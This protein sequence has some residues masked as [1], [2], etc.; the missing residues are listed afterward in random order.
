MSAQHF[1]APGGHYTGL[2][3]YNEMKPRAFCTQHPEK[4]MRRLQLWNPAANKVV[5]ARGVPILHVWEASVAAARAHIGF[6]DCRP[7]WGSDPGL[8]D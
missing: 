4:E 7:I 2:E 5:A 1:S 3:N 6:G 8:A